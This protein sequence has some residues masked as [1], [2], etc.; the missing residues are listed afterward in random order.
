MYICI[1][2]VKRSFPSTK[3][4]IRKLSRIVKPGTPTRISSNAVWMIGW[5]SR[6]LPVPLCF[7]MLLEC[8]WRTIDAALKFPQLP[9]LYLVIQYSEIL[10]SRSSSLFGFVHNLKIGI[11][12]ICTLCIYDTAHGCVWMAYSWIE[13]SGFAVYAE[14]EVSDPDWEARRATGKT[15]GH[16]RYVLSW[17]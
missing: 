5:K 3:R 4:I 12:W 10:L 13:S 7:L 8:N 6:K 14:D 9:P 1:W 16:S 15:F 17:I 2:K 11:L